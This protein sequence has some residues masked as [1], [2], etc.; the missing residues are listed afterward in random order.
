[1][2]S[3]HRFNRRCLKVRHCCAKASGRAPPR[4]SVKARWAVDLLR[5]ISL[6][7]ADG[8]MPGGGF[9]QPG[10]GL[11]LVADMV[12]IVTPRRQG[13]LAL[14]LPR[15]AVGFSNPKEEEEEGEGG[16]II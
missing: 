13:A 7:A 3:V 4:I 9:G 16:G 11:S 6:T 5:G 1:M 15:G 2:P 14:A 8:G 10:P 12:L